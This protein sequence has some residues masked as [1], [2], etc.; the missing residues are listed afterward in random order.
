M[1]PSIPVVSE[2]PMVNTSLLS[3]ATLNNF[4]IFLPS[5]L[6][7]RYAVRNV[8]SYFLPGQGCSPFELKYLIKINVCLKSFY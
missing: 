4:D 3:N 6:F 2:V 8:P 7:G 5:A 1:T